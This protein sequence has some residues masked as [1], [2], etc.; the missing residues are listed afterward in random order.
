MVK[1]IYFTT[2]KATINYNVNMHIIIC[3][4]QLAPFLIGVV[5]KSISLNISPYSHD[6]MHGNLL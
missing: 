5:C 1:F 3:L 6:K 4:V 2:L